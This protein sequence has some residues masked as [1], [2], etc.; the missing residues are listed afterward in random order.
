MNFHANN[1]QLCLLVDSRQYNEKVIYK[2]FYW[3]TN[4][5][6]VDIQIDTDPFYKITLRSNKESD[7]VSWDH[8]IE[9]IKKDLIDFKL[10]DIVNQETQ[11]IREL[12]VAKAFAYYDLQETPQTNISDPVGFNPE[13]V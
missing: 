9:K 2:C 7:S 8:I 11:T 4:E 12:I 6:S 10:R 13:N 3:Y 1:E 5:Y